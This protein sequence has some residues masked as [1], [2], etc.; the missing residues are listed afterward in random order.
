MTGLDALVDS[1]MG[2]VDVYRLEPSELP[3]KSAGS[4]ED[5]VWYFFCRLDYKYKNSKRASRATESGYWKV[6]GKP[7]FILAR[8]SGDQIGV[9]KTL[10]FFYRARGD[11]KPI[12]TQWVIHEY[13]AA[14]LLPDQKEYV[15]CKLKHKGDDW[16][17]G[18]VSID[19]EHSHAAPVYGVENHGPAIPVQESATA[20]QSPVWLEEGI[21]I[22]DFLGDDVFTNETNNGSTFGFEPDEELDPDSYLGIP[23]DGIPQILRDNVYSITLLNK[24]NVITAGVIHQGLSEHEA[25][26]FG[27]QAQSKFPIASLHQDSNQVRDRGFEYQSLYKGEASYFMPQAQAKLASASTCKQSNLFV[28]QGLGQMTRAAEAGKGRRLLPEATRATKSSRFTNAHSALESSPA[29]SAAE[30]CKGPVSVIQMVEI[31]ASNVLNSPTV[32]IANILLVLAL[33]NL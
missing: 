7:R 23:D 3:C 25:S 9:K 14:E 26:Y 4:F 22:D 20:M 5:Q 16:T 27:G 13:K 12:S 18:K 30:A 11:I 28:K 31:P 1:V 33:F 2:E 6:T 32:Y 15:I 21:S 10:V 24:V 17:K 29:A 19:G 8:D